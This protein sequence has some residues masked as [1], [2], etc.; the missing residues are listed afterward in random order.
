MDL[1]CPYCK[2]EL[3]INHD[4]GFGFDDI[5]THEMECEHCT[6]S[7]VFYTEIS[8][9]YTPKKADC[10]NGSDHDWKLTSTSPKEL[11]Q[12]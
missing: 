4:D 9:C 2:E 1:E 11:S 10:L 7:F 8:F 12:M 6:K 3:E 5:D